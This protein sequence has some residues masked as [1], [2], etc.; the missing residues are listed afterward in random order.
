VVQPVLDQLRNFRVL[1]LL[2]VAAL[3]VPAWAQDPPPKL[4]IEWNKTIIVSKSTPTLQVVTNPMLNH[5]STIHDSSFTA[6]KTLGADFVR[7][8]PWL[9]YPKI[10]VAELTPPTKDQTSWDFRYIDPVIKDFFAATEGHPTIVNFSTIPAW[11][12][13]TDKPVEYPDNPN[14]VF[15]NYSQGKEL[16]DP[17]GRELSDYFARIVSWYSKG[18]FTDEDGKRHESGYHYK[19]PYWEVLN[20]V[21]LEHQTTPEDY[22]KRYDA[23]VEGI[24]RVSP[25]TKF[26]GI[27]LAMAGDD[28]NYYEYFLNP[29]NHKPGIPLD[30]ISFHFYATPAIDENLDVWQH[31]FFNQAEGF[32]ATTR[33]I[34]AIRDRLSPQTK[35]DTDE[36]GVI[37]PTDLI[38]IAASKA[39]PDHIPHRYWN[40]AAAL[41]GYL[42]VELS[43]L[44]VD[45]IG[46]SQ[47]VGYPSQFP[48]VSMID[49]NN[50]KPNA[51]YWVLKIIKDNFHPGDKL[52][53]NSLQARGSSEV[54]IQ[55]FITSEGKKALLVNKTNSPKTVILSPEF[56]GARSLT[57]DEATGDE[58]ARVG[59]TGGAAL[60]MAPFAVTVLSIQ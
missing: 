59:T 29:K 10:A 28:P 12:F 44:G 27:A 35:T 47:L 40:A 36:L 13:K 39:M 26:M 24:H 30:F 42:F 11:M 41:Y 19:I 55:G 31:T 15:W 22:T 1:A 25:D 4:D 50:G 58:E 8:V 54:M 16:R 14:Q 32:L 45:V 49:Y 21:D 37:L 52:V 57:V 60:K 38:E 51:R 9:P 48:S 7:F 34:L 5:G 17:A 20:E 56:K 46:E 33:F 2:L 6:L 43:K 18:G 53:E 3:R 23:I